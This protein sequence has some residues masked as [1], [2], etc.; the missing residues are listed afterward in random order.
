MY[1]E[2]WEW[3]CLVIFL[4]YVVGCIVCTFHSSYVIEF[5]FSVKVTT[6]SKTRS[7]DLE[8]IPMFFAS[9][10]VTPFVPL[11]VLATRHME[12]KNIDVLDM[13]NRS[14]FLICIFYT[15][16]IVTP[17]ICGGFYMFRYEANPYNVCFWT[18]ITVAIFYFSDLFKFELS[19]PASEED[20]KEKEK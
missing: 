16:T 13:K 1:S 18:A 7:F 8:K 9:I 17:I 3:L 19:V 14:W 20:S 6:S 11:L 4:L 15:L 10:I 5:I 12:K 2:V